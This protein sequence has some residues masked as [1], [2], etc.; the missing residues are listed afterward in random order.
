MIRKK[1][2]S[3]PT[4]R[5]LWR[6]TILCIKKF[7]LKGYAQNAVEPTLR[8]ILGLPGS[9]LKAVL[10]DA[11]DVKLSLA[12]LL[13]TLS[14]AEKEEATSGRWAGIEQLSESGEASPMDNDKKKVIDD[15]S[16]VVV[17]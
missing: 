1:I 7:V 13:K 17:Q 16:A 8:A 3:D 6:G 9:H 11:D 5:D 2:W 12:K 15:L 4:S 14:T 10:A